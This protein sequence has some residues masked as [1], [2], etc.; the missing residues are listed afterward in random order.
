VHVPIGGKVLN[1][2]KHLPDLPLYRAGAFIADMIITIVCAYL[3]HS[4]IDAPS[5][6]WAKR[7]TS[8]LFLLFS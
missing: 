4:F 1:L 8:K 5:L 6:R 7:A 2:S 3:F